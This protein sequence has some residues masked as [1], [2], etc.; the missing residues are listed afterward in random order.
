MAYQ[1]FESV[2]IDN[3]YSPVKDRAY[4]PLMLEGVARQINRL[5]NK[6]IKACGCSY[7]VY[8]ANFS[9]SVDRIVSQAKDRDLRATI[10]YVAR[11]CDY[12]SPEE[13]DEMRQSCLDAGLCVHGIA[14]DCCPAGCGDLP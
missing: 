8:I 9:L 2:D 7:E 6:N 14:P 10:L 11:E 1:N 5:A 12:H 4:N 3:V 13:V